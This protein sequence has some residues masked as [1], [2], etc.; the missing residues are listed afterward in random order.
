MA[1]GGAGLDVRGL[2]SGPDGA[3]AIE[4]VLRWC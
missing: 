4:E 3:L 1:A 2:D